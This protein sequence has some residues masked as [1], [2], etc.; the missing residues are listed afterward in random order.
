MRT[1]SGSTRRA[2]KVPIGTAPAR[3]VYTSSTS[4][5]GKYLA[6]MKSNGPTPARATFS[7]RDWAWRGKVMN[8]IEDLCEQGVWTA[9]GYFDLSPAAAKTLRVVGRTLLSLRDFYGPLNSRTISQHLR[10]APRTVQAGLRELAELQLITYERRGREM[11]ELQLAFGIFAGAKYERMSP[12]PPELSTLSTIRRRARPKATD[13]T[14]NFALQYHQE[15]IPTEES[16]RSDSIEPPTA[17]PAAGSPQPPLH[18]EKE[19][20]RNG[21][22]RPTNGIERPRQHGMNDKSRRGVRGGAVAAVK[23]VVGVFERELT[24]LFGP[25]PPS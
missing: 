12:R 23:S 6:T 22:A 18:G 8:L 1:Q 2:G 10:T 20:P 21:A 15:Q 7:E 9:D 25:A 4:L 17:E 5:F 16:V 19:T 14:Q 13:R 3:Y 11:V 24:A